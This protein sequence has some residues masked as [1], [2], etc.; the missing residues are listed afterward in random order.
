M[1]LCLDNII[2]FTF[3]TFHPVVA[4]ALGE[5]DVTFVE[6]YIYLYEVVGNDIGY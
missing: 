6:I 3:F 4:T 1:A 5:G 2:F